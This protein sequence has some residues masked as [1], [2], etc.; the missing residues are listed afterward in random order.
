MFLVLSLLLSLVSL[1]TSETVSGHQFFQLYSTIIPKTR[2]RCKQ[3]GG[4]E[5]VLRS[6]DDPQAYLSLCSALCPSPVL[7]VFCFDLVWGS[8]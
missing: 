6:S 4:R 2:G 7:L 3:C 1:E 5:S 8:S